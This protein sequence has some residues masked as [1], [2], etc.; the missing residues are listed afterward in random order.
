MAFKKNAVLIPKGL[1]KSGNSMASV[2]IIIIN[3]NTFQLTCNCIESIY[4]KETS[5]DFEIIVVDNASSECDPLAFKKKFPQIELI[6]NDVNLGFAKGNN[7]GISRAQGDFILLLNS[8]TVLLNNAISL[9]KEFMEADK[10]VGVVSSRLEYPDGKPQHNCQRFPSV[11][12]KLFELLRLQK[13]TGRSKAGKVLFGYFFSYDVVA[14]PDWTWGT[15]FLFRT[16]ILDQLPAKRL[17]EIFFMYVEDMQW[18][19]DFHLMGY[20]VAFVPQARVLHLMGMSKGSKNEMMK[21]N[22]NR[23]MQMYY[24]AF[25]RCLIKILDSLLKFQF[26]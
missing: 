2:S 17:S 1:T 20:K 26:K 24:T 23:F 5:L 8:D 16:K 25:S 12:Y 9:C 19:M 13:I 3:Y 15:F 10:R 18:C 4:K 22:E 14:Y 6:R 21:Q 7:V 11:K